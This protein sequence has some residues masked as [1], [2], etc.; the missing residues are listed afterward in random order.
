MG[1]GVTTQAAS[2]PPPNGTPGA[3]KEKQP[4]SSQRLPR[5]RTGAAASYCETGRS[6]P[7]QSAACPSRP[8]PALFSPPVL[9]AVKN[10]S[11]PD[12]ARKNGLGGSPGVVLEPLKSTSRLTYPRTRLPN[13][14]G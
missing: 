1:R 13:L 3:W 14:G 7:S 9:Q 12:L 5:G 6:C 8:K 2:L 4:P 10:D 11:G